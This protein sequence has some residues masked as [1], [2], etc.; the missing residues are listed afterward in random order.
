M[1][2]PSFSSENYTPDRLHA[3]DHPLETAD[4][5]ILTGQNL[6]RGTV[7]GKATRGAAS[8]VADGGNTGDGTVSAV[9]VGNAAEVGDYVI[10]CTAAA[11]N[12]GTFEVVSPSGDMLDDLSVGV[13]Y[14]NGH[15]GLTI[16]D[17]ATD[18]IVGD[19]VTVTVATGSGKCVVVNSAN[20][21]GTEVAFA[22][23]AQDTDAS[24][25][26]KV[27]PVYLAGDFNEDQLTFGGSDTAATHRDAM[28]DRGM[29]LKSPVSA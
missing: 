7:L 26:D 4:A 22:V 12:G 13:A 25:A 19:K 28:R 11:A 24:A 16:A 23:L 6:T 29:Y 1:S 10:T 5:T 9:T 8:A 27:A 2:D 20:T 3:G 14:S 17:G 18:W 21:D 15:L